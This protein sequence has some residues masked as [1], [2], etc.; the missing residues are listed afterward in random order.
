MG[1]GYGFTLVAGLVQLK[2]LATRLPPK[3]LGLYFA[4][5][6]GVVM[7]AELA[8]S[9]L[10][11]LYSHEVPR[12]E[13]LGQEPGSLLLW[14]N[15]WHLG[16]LLLI[17]LVASATG[18]RGASLAAAGFGLQVHYSLAVSGVLARRRPGLYAAL[19]A[20]AAWAYA[21]GLLA[22]GDAL[23]PERA[24][25]TLAA[26]YGLFSALAWGFSRPKLGKPG[27]DR[28]LLRYWKFSFLTTALSPVFFQLDRVLAGA[29]L[30][31][32][33][34]ALL[35][36]A[37]RIEIV[38]RN[39][40]AI[41]LDAMAPEAS[42]AWTKEGRGRVLGAMRRFTWLYL[43]LALAGLLAIPLLGRP[44][45]SL[46]ASPQYAPAARLL[47][48]LWAGASLGTLYYHYNTAARAAGEMGLYFWG[49]A[50][51]VGS[52]LLISLTLLKPLGLWGLALAPL[53]ATAC[54]LTYSWSRVFPWLGE[55]QRPWRGL[56]VFLLVFG[57]SLGLEALL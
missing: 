16:W 36:V 9:G 40:L 34:A 35:G 5:Q 17:F 6:A 22:W 28:R 26:V 27:L 57:L 53:G 51:W 43:G 12:R 38:G 23:T 45:I 49:D 39:I 41:P 11:L 15:L 3:E 52:Y 42:F 2:T 37:R 50:V 29:F 32:E 46:V 21:L 13:A 31:L 20:S 54:A 10:N 8:K 56:L 18:L 48:V 14:G 25:A 4:L 47:L 24:F 44:V 55:R 33:A 19:N 1:V 30:S 7:A